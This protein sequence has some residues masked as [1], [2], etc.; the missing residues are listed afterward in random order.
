MFGLRERPCSFWLLSKFGNIV[1]QL[2]CYLLGMLTGPEKIVRRIVF[3]FSFFQLD[4]R[5][6]TCYSQELELLH[7]FSKEA[8][9]PGHMLITFLCDSD[10]TFLARLLIL[11]KKGGLLQLKFGGGGVNI[12]LW[13]R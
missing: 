5:R 7:R 13:A 8:T 11:I 9:Y 4:G 3:L 10:I 2:K 6:I 12:Y 1:M